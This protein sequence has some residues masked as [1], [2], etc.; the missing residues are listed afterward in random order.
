MWGYSDAERFY[1][2]LTSLKQIGKL[3][4]SKQKM[5]RCYK[6][7]HKLL[8]CDCVRKYLFFF[9]LLWYGTYYKKKCWC[10]HRISTRTQT[11]NMQELNMYIYEN[12]QSRKNVQ[13][14][15]RGNTF[16]TFPWNIDEHGWATECVFLTKISVRQWCSRSFRSGPTLDPGSLTLNAD[17]KISGS[18]AHTHIYPA[19]HHCQEE[20]STVQVNDVDV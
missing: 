13:P 12:K 19:L 8:V 17:W 2:D 18:T 16:E 10:N 14:A 6:N 7:L 11:H 1:E 5:P 9:L 15:V 4:K 3:Q 20:P